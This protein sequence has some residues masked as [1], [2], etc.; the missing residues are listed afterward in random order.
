M[1][2]EERRKAVGLGNLILSI[3][4][5]T[6]VGLLLFAFVNG[7]FEETIYEP[8]TRLVTVIV[9]V[10]VAYALL[11]RHLAEAFGELVWAKVVRVQRCRLNPFFDDRG[12]QVKGLKIKV[13]VN[14]SVHTFRYTKSFYSGDAE[15]VSAGHYVAVYKLGPFMS[16]DVR[17]RQEWEENEYT[18]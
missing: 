15:E 11:H 13:D 2:K 12:T 16:I 8:I 14:G 18:R 17:R 4:G 6:F 5:V 9:Y 3:V 7:M 1:N 10:I